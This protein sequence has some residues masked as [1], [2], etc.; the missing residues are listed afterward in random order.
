ME[1]T[2]LETML[3]GNLLF[4]PNIYFIHAENIHSEL[5]TSNTNRQI[6]NAYKTI[7]QAGKTPDTISLNEILKTNYP[8]I[9]TELQ[10]IENSNIYYT[11]IENIISILQNNYKIS[12]LKWIGDFLQSSTENNPQNLIKFISDELTKLSGSSAKKIT[13][14]TEIIDSII[15]HIKNQKK[16]EITGIETGLTEYDIHSAGLHPT[17]LII[18]AGETSQ[19]K[20]SLGISMII[21][22]ILN[23]IPVLFVS[24]EMSQMQLAAR[25]IS[26]EIK[27][28]SKTILFHNISGHELERMIT[29]METL[30]QIPFYMEN[31]SSS[32]T[33]II[34][35]IRRYVIQRQIKI[36]IIDYIQLVRNASKGVSR[37][38]SVGEVARGFKNIAM[39]LNITVI[40]I[41]QLNRDKDNPKPT[42]ARLRASGEIEEAADQVIFVWRP[43][44]Y[45][46]NPLFKGDVISWLDRGVLDV[47]KGRNIGIDKFLLKF[48]KE[49][50][51]W[52]NLPSEYQTQEIPY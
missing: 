15:E 13:E 40:A 41:S 42:L 10:H 29:K 1:N 23:N 45:E 51:M 44:Y 9:F 4:D 20:T 31:S 2:E 34:N 35:T 11:G 38:D 52:E 47:A 3:L 25:I 5:F 30:R 32:Y 50:T 37:A 12:K 14:F 48:N 8:N 46:L 28:S 7:V 21:K 36:V 24:L 16:G 17:D 26:Q 43:E 22:P 49:L 39:E 27:T 18:V 6:F 33:D 19:G